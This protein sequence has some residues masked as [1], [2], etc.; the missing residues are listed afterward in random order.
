M[1]RLSIIA[2]LVSF[3]F[4]LSI[5]FL[6][7]QNPSK[8]KSSVVPSA[9]SDQTEKLK[10]EVLTTNL[11]V[12]WAIALLPDQRMKE[13]WRFIHMDTGILKD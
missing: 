2:I 13:K 4:F 9:V 5:A 11:E 12:P 7:R 1:N 10:V 3:A 6:F 8:F